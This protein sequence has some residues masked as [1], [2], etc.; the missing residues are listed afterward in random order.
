MTPSIVRSARVVGVRAEPVTITVRAVAGRC[1]IAFPASMINAA[2]SETRHRVKAA[3]ETAGFTGLRGSAVDI[4]PPGSL[5]PAF[6]LPIAVGILAAQGLVQV[7][8]NHIIAGELA[9]NGALRPLRGAVPFARL[10]TE[11]QQPLLLPAASMR[12]AALGVSYVFLQG[13]GS[14]ADAV[15]VL[16]GEAMGAPE[17]LRD[18][19]PIEVPLL[20]DLSPAL[21]GVALRVAEVVNTGKPV[22]IVG[23]P[24][25]GKTRVARRIPGLMPPPTPEELLEIAT[26]RSAA[27][28]LHGR[29]LDIRRP[30]RAPHH[31][32]STA[33]LVGGGQF[34]RPGE[35]TLAHNGVLFLDEVSEFRRKALGCL[36]EVWHA[37]QATVT[38]SSGSVAMP[39]DLAL[40]AAC[41]PCPCGWNGSGQRECVCGPERVKRYWKRLPAWLRE[42]AVVIRMPEVARCSTASAWTGSTSS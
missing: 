33:G 40:V 17:E 41:N 13:A 6:D 22:L 38:R 12:E 2:A 18:E 28:M 39:A 35:A 21:Q 3:L 32:C 16:R 4:D 37:K 14:L 20:S 25:T 15:A 11:Q 42:E 26:V 29:S 7:E 27:G 10:A 8:P 36:H 19:R 24:G 1:D 5:D 9:V 34:L 23:S 31:T 30:F